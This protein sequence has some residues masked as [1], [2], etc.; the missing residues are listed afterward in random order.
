MTTTMETRMDDIDPA[1]QVV[2]IHI[3]SIVKQFLAIIT[4]ASVLM[5]SD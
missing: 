1:V 5:A 4:A 3:S 2:G